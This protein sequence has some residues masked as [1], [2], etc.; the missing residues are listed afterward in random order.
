MYLCHCEHGR[1]SLKQVTWITLKN[2][3]PRVLATSVLRFCKHLRNLASQSQCERV[4]GEL[5][6]IPCIHCPDSIVNGQ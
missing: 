4:N 1:L 6:H 2:S 3:A 5:L